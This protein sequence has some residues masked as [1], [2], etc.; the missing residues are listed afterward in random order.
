MKQ[1]VLEATSEH[2]KLDKA[3]P[4][5]K[6]THSKETTT[7]AGEDDSSSHGTETTNDTINDDSYSN[8]LEGLAV[9]TNN[10]AEKDGGGVAE[11]E[12]TSQDE[13]GEQENESK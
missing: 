5:Q 3:E 11:T 7:L 9:N 13:T 12:S 2:N 1:V 6:Q 4:A 8:K 10:E